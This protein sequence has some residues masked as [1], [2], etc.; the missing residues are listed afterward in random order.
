MEESVTML[1][2]N[3]LLLTL[4]LGSLTLFGCDN[5][6]IQQTAKNLGIDEVGNLGSEMLLTTLKAECDNQL[7]NNAAFADLI[8]TPEQKANLC[9]CTGN[10]I[11]T[12]MSSEA[13][14]TLAKN[15]SIDSQVIIDKVAEAMA[16]C[17]SRDPKV[18]TVNPDEV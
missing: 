17:T 1:T 9:Q 10:Q 18:Q 11:K 5:P 2:S 3:K 15:G 6:H 4:I 8:L 13:L 16:I 14:L 12:S 7:N